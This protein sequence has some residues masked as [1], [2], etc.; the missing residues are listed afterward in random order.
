MSHVHHGT[1]AGE[2]IQ[3]PAAGPAGAAAA[4]GQRHPPPGGRHGG[5][6]EPAAAVCCGPGPSGCN[7]AYYGMLRAL[8]AAILCCG[9]A[10]P[11]SSSPAWVS[12]TPRTWPGTWCLP[13][14][15]RAAPFWAAHW[16][17]PPAPC[18]ISASR[19][20]SAAWT[21]KAAFRLAVRELIARL[22]GW[23]PP[24]AGAAGAGPARLPVQHLQLPGSVGAGEGGSA[25]GDSRGGG[26]PAQRHRPPTATGAA[27]PPV[28]TSGSRAAALRRPHG[29]GGVSGRSAGATPW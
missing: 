3:R 28:S 15:R 9:A 16:W 1:V 6:A 24:A 12:F 19:P 27:I 13:P 26:G 2:P 14:I 18:G 22:D 21:K 29:G 11:G 8:R 20:R 7:L 5:P 17:R 10:W 25:A 23:R 4:S